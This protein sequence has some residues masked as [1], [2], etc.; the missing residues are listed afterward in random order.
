VSLIQALN[1]PPLSV[2]GFGPSIPY[3]KEDLED[4]EDTNKQYK[5]KG[6]PNYTKKFYKG[7]NNFYS[8]EVNNISSESS[9]NDDD[10]VLFLGIEEPNDI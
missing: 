5:K 4:E 10:E 3:P 9:D 7:K 6:K 1:T 2:T 8:K